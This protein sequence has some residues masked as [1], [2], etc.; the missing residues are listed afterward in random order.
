VPDGSTKANCCTVG[1]RLRLALVQRCFRH[2]EEHI[3]HVSRRGA[4]RQQFGPTNADA[5]HDS[6]RKGALTRD[7]VE[8]FSRRWAFL[9]CSGVAR[10]K[11][12]F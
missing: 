5:I 9:G 6:G 11:H 1:H 2:G 3:E 4:A 10:I 12:R 8:L 7:I